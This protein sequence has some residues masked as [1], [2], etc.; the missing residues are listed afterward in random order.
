MQLD[1]ILPWTAWTKQVDLEA[2]WTALTSKEAG[3]S[4]SA[5]IAAM[6]A[7]RYLTKKSVDPSIPGPKA[8]S[9]LFGHA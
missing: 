5:V 7:I 2:L 1:L 3:L 4:V 8:P 9:F 6:L